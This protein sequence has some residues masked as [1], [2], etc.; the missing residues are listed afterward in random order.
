M[1]RFLKSDSPDFSSVTARIISVYESGRFTNFGNMTEELEKILSKRFIPDGLKYKTLAVNNATNGIESCIRA[2]LG[3]GDYSKHIAVP[4]FTFPATISAIVNSGY[5]PKYVDIFPDGHEWEFLANF[6]FTKDKKVDVAAFMPVSAFGRDLPDSYIEAAKKEFR[7]IIADTAPAFFATKINKNVAAYIFSLHATKSI[8]TGGEGGFCIIGDDY[9][10]RLKVSVNFG[11]RNG[12]RDLKPEDG[13]SNSKMAEIPACFAI[14]S[15]NN[16]D[17]TLKK[18]VE[19]FEK[20]NLAESNRWNWHLLPVKVRDAGAAF[21]VFAECGIETKRY[22]Y[23]QHRSIEM[24]NTI[25]AYSTLICVPFYSKLT[26]EEIEK[27][28]VVTEN[29]QS[30]NRRP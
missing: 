1:I 22:Y 17:E 20:L 11:L 19:I 3:Q 25:K 13:T 5:K 2:V 24:P 14:S 16:A 30:F 12:D 9:Y 8:T 15:V 28:R 26:D 21:K 23:P 18:R 27:I 6:S 4:S 29:V 7:Y 10:E